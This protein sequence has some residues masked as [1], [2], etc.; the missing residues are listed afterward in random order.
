MA[1][2]DQESSKVTLIIY[3]ILLLYLMANILAYIVIV[4]RVYK[5]NFNIQLNKICLVIAHPDDECLFFGPIIRSLLKQ[6][7]EV[8]ILCLSNGNYYGLGDTREKE[9]HKSC[10]CLSIESNRIKFKI[11][12]S[13]EL[14]DHPTKE[15][16]SENILYYVND[17]LKENDINSILSFD[18]RGISSHRNHCDI[19]RAL[20]S[21][22]SNYTI[23]SLQTVSI[24]RKYSFLFDLIPTLVLNRQNIICLNT[25]N[26]YLALL[27][28]MHSHKSQFLWF[29]I[30]YLFTSRYMLINNLI[31]LK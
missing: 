19:S 13:N 14:Q 22:S 3:F 17:Y 18:E 7:I 5:L 10:N 8:Y 25:P 9:F 21:L 6:N 11:I 2:N 20:L 27:K 28:A 15:W 31:R 1:S 30:I 12:N 4:T 23:Y 26:D 24:L 16:S 29:R